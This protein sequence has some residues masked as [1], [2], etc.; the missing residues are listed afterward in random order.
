MPPE[1][2]TRS[3]FGYR[4]PLGC[5]SIVF[6]RSTPRVPRRPRRLRRGFHENF[7]GPLEGKAVTFPILVTEARWRGWV[8]KS[9]QWRVLASGFRP[10]RPATAGGHSPQ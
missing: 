3:G 6:I 9:L 10:F 5:R 8:I 2:F 4:E 7:H 1:R